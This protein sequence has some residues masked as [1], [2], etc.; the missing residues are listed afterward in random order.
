ML[1]AFNVVAYGNDVM[2][3]P[4]MNNVPESLTN[5]CCVLLNRVYLCDLRPDAVIALPPYI[6]LR[7][8]PPALND[9]DKLLILPYWIIVS[10]WRSVKLMTSPSA[11]KSVRLYENCGVMAVETL[12]IDTLYDDMVALVA[13]GG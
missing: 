12:N 6:V 1:K 8:V 3:G 2:P 10:L 4:L 7:V 13:L 11:S 5:I 9:T